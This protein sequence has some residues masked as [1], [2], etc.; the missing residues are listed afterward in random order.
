MRS[1]TSNPTCDRCSHPAPIGHYCWDEKR[2]RAAII[3][4]IANSTGDPA[5]VADEIMRRLKGDH[6][7]PGRWADD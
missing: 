1:T 6:L 7:I 3:R 2:A 5:E 4:G